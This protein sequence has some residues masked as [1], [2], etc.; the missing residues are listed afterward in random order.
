MSDD[1]VA[2]VA[3]FAA[4]ADALGQP[5]ALIDRAG[6]LI[7][8]SRRFDREV[9][10][11]RG[12]DSLEALADDDPDTVERRVASW[13]ASS[14][15]V[16]GALSFGGVAHRGDGARLPGRE[17]AVIRF[18][19]RR[20]TTRAFAEL[21]RTVDIHRLEHTK[22][23]L[24]VALR[25]LGEANTALASSNEELD[26]F[27]SV[28]SHDL[29]TPLAVIA[30]LAGLLADS[31]LDEDSR[32]LVEAIVRNADQLHQQVEAIL[33]VARFGSA[34]PPHTPVELNRALAE[35]RA[36]LDARLVEVDAELQVDELPAVMVSEVELVQLF[37]NLVENAVKFRRLDRPLRMRVRAVVDGGRVHI[38]VA[39]N[40]MGIAAHDRQRLFDLF[41][42]GDTDR[43]GTGVGLATCR[44][45][46]MRHR[47]HIR[48]DDGIDGGTAFHFDLP[49]LP[50]PG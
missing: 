11:Q 4:I 50:T 10:A 48:I 23:R 37:Q 25:A 13:F 33:A 24:R 8:T 46:V 1:D 17:S 31:D 21:T 41:A 42:R 27:A 38:T 5:A 20:D 40:G 7:A 36:R 28:V 14:S 45:I 43:P 44:R 39:D 12:G 22:Q 2:V 35:V 3:S 18:A 16:P 15:P 47:G 9:R 34:H 19:P 6:K 29:R 30:G 49:L 26:R 32:A